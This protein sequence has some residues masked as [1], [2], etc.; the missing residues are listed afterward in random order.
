[1]SQSFSFWIEITLLAG[2]TF[3]LV[4]GTPLLNKVS[5]VQ[6]LLTERS[7]VETDTS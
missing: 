5:Y 4:I 3:G 6:T 2:K 1:M 7:H